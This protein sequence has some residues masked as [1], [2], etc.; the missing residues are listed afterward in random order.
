MQWRH[1]ELN[2]YHAKLMAK[3]LRAAKE[4]KFVAQ[5]EVKKMIQKMGRTR[6]SAARVGLIPGGEGA[7]CGGE[8]R[9]RSTIKNHP[10]TG[11]APPG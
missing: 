7:D 2:E 6:R 3:G 1:L 4:G 5:A 8:D 11:E 10:V 9:E